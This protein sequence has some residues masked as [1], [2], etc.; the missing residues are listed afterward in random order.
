[1][2]K[3]IFFYLKHMVSDRIIIIINNNKEI[4]G[5]N[6]CINGYN[7]YYIKTPKTI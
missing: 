2:L 1:M 6:S 7:F 3:K 4:T 5:M